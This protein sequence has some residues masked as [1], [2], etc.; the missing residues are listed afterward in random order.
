MAQ[1]QY[2]TLR[3]WFD[4]VW[5]IREVKSTFNELATLMAGNG[6]N[7]NHLDEYLDTRQVSTLKE[8]WELMG[9]Y[10]YVSYTKFAEALNEHIPANLPTI[11]RD[12]IYDWI[13]GRRFPEAA[14]DRQALYALTALPCFKVEGKAAVRVMP[15]KDLRTASDLEVLFH[16]K[17]LDNALEVVWK[18]LGT[19]TSLRLTGG[20]CEQFEKNILAAARTFNDAAEE[21]E[22]VHKLEKAING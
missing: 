7:V 8:W 17:L 4:E 11:K 21:I 22:A 1:S 6:F 2:I 19:L 3:Y 15:V 20:N 9:K 16:L 13:S 14:E 18:E 10:L 5:Q 12:S